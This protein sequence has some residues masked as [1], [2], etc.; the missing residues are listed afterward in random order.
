M[1]PERTQDLAS[2][3]FR[4]IVRRF[5]DRATEIAAFTKTGWSFEEWLNWEAYAACSL[6]RG[7]ECD[8]RPRYIRLGDHPSCTGFGDLLVTE[9][10]GCVLIEVGLVHDGTGDKWRAKLD[11]DMDKLARPLK[12][13]INTLQV[14][15][16][17]S[18]QI[19]IAER[20]QS[21]LEKC[22]CWRPTQLAES[23]NL[24]GGGEIVIRGWAA[25][26]ADRVPAESGPVR[27]DVLAR[28]AARRS[29]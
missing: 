11:R 19:A 21:W 2:R 3:V 29:R 5:R 14:I 9:G 13:G 20:W 16:L 18:S 1:R 25:T 24:P 10:E 7:W 23:E 8:A 17:V 22:S 12:R 27:L 28:R 15:V 4:T 26:A 6:V